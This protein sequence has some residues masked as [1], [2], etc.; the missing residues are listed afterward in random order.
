MKNK[1]YSKLGRKEGK[2]AY[3]TPSVFKYKKSVQVR[4]KKIE[5]ERF[6]KKKF[7]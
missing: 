1:N 6:K 7:F 5:R 4:R 2:P 3:R